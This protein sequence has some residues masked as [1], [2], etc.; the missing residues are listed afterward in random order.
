MNKTVLNR[1]HPGFKPDPQIAM[2]FND[3]NGGKML[4][5]RTWQESDTIGNVEINNAVLATTSSDAGNG[6]HE[7]R[8]GIDSNRSATG[9]GSALP[10]PWPKS[11]P[12]ASAAMH[13]NSRITFK[14]NQRRARDPTKIRF[15]DRR[16][17]RNFRLFSISK[18]IRFSERAKT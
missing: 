8:G 12:P 17:V 15:H 10:W 16:S 3:D 11:I 18:S 13:N 6:K 1:T 2:N 4:G 9:L 14:F 5:P 7:A